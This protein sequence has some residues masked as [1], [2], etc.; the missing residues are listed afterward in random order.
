MHL[1]S[2]TAT[3]PPRSTG[4]TGTDDFDDDAPRQRVLVVDAA[5]H[6]LAIPVER[7]REVQRT[8]RVTTV[9]GSPPVLF[10]IA[11][12]RGA[13]VTVLDL[14]V[15]LEA[16]FSRTEEWP[17][18]RSAPA[19]RAHRG[20][21]T[22]SIVLLEHGSQVI[23]LR[24]DAV[25]EV[26]ARDDAPLAPPSVAAH[27]ESSAFMHAPLAGVVRAEG[28]DIALLD[29]DALFSRYLLSTE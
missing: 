27:L 25:R 12:V 4:Q 8:V 26:P 29:V 1:A 13:V 6:R 9:P 21:R 23:G 18:A 20:E 17:V 3:N 24:V 2:T 11:N 15:A 10:G 22:G 7:V 19:E 14:S 16:P 5:G 28:E